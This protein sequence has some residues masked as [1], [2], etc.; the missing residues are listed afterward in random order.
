MAKT[1]SSKDVESV[2]Y[3]LNFKFVS[4]CGSNA[5]FKNNNGNIVILLMNRKDIPIGTLRNIFKQ[6]GITYEE[7][8][9]V[10]ME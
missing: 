4:Q 9:K 10:C 7:F 6:I 5:K 1:Y 3:K 2:L 8:R